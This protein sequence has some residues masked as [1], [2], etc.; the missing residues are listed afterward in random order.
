MVEPNRA[1]GSESNSRAVKLSVASDNPRWTYGQGVDW[2]RGV[3]GSQPGVTCSPEK[4]RRRFYLARTH[5][6]CSRSQ[7]GTR[8]ISGRN[9]CGHSAAAGTPVARRRSMELR[10]L[11]RKRASA[12]GSQQ[13]ALCMDIVSLKLP[14]LQWGLPISGVLRA[15]LQMLGT[16]SIIKR[17]EA[18]AGT[19]VHPPRQD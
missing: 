6:P 1:R 3:R 18:E 2:G 12:E 9:Q 13:G 16:P 8:A 5:P 19:Q 10:G 17:P 14:S 7:R 11:P 4:A 15:F